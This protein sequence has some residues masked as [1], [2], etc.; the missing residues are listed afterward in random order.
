M[1]TKGP[2]TDLSGHLSWTDRQKVK[3]RRGGQEGTQGQR[4][5]SN[6]GFDQLC[7]ALQR[8]GRAPRTGC[9][10]PGCEGN[11]PV[12]PGVKVKDHLQL[13]SEL[14]TCFYILSLP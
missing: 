1:K 7:T 10:V 13:E 5:S 6:E 8:A 11:S 12:S 3:L 14:I 2:G 4:V 9:I